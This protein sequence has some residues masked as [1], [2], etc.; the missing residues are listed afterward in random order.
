VIALAANG[1]ALMKPGSF[2]NAGGKDPE[3][4]EF[5]AGNGCT[6]YTGGK[7]N[8]FARI[9][10]AEVA[11][12]WPRLCRRWKTINLGP[13]CRLAKRTALRGRALCP[14][15]IRHGTPVDM[16]RSLGDARRR[17]KTRLMTRTSVSRAGPLVL[18][19]NPG[20]VT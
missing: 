16:P 5:D 9:S 14:A 3:I 2:A 6:T 12:G 4:C 19:L 1:A 10:F 13:N 15:F 8:G 18:L 7:G 11:A 17:V 20:P